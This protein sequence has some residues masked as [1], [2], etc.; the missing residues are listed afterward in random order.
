MAQTAS[1]V[2]E[3]SRLVQPPPRGHE[4]EEV[5]V[6]PEIALRAELFG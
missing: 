1:D 4:I 6:P 3:R 2:G 5:A